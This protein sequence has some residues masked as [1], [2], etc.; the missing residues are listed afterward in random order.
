MDTKKPTKIEYPG[1]RSMMNDLKKVTKIRQEM[2]NREQEKKEVENGL[3]QVIK[4]QK[5]PLEKRIQKNLFVLKR[6]L[7][8]MKSEN[9]DIKE[10]EKRIEELYN[11]FN[12]YKLSVYLSK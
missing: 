3:I 11:D 9:A 1:R 10:I 6:K 7:E 5:I 12:M 2:A 4:R 8:R